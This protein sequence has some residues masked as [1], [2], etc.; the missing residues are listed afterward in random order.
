MVY[1]IITFMKYIFFNIN[2]FK[3]IES[4]WFF[5]KN[6]MVPLIGYNGSGK[7]NFL[8]SIHWFDIYNQKDGALISNKR[9]KDLKLKITAEILLKGS[10]DSSVLNKFFKDL[11]KK[12]TKNSLLYKELCGLNYLNN[13]K[14]RLILE[15]SWFEGVSYYIEGTEEFLS[16]L[17]KEKSE[18]ISEYNA[19]IKV[20]FNNLPWIYLFSGNESKELIIQKT[21]IDPMSYNKETRNKWYDILN[22]IIKRFSTDKKFDLEYIITK[23]VTKYEIEQLQID[24]RKGLN[25]DLNINDIFYFL[26]GGDSIDTELW[27]NISKFDSNQLVEIEISIVEK[28]GDNLSQVVPMSEMST[29]FKNLINSYF[30]I[31]FSGKQENRIFLL[32]EPTNY[33]SNRI[34]KLL[35]EK[36]KK[37]TDEIKSSFLFSTHNPFGI[38]LNYIKTDEII[39]AEKNSNNLTQIMNINDCDFSHEDTKNYINKILKFTDYS[40]NNLNIEKDKINVIVEGLSDFRILNCVLENDKYNILIMEGFKKYKY[41]MNSCSKNNC[42]F[43]FIIDTN[44]KEKEYFDEE[45]NK[46]K[47]TKNILKK[48]FI[49]LNDININFNQIEDLVNLEEWIA[50]NNHEHKNYSLKCKLLDNEFDKNFFS[51]IKLTT[52]NFILLKTSIEN[53]VN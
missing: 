3:N 44:S 26:N 8:E 43:I 2:N 32:D 30:L 21:V 38:D 6:N 11:G 31:S 47:I 34:M 36:M 24:I 19:Y 45:I 20:L 4:G 51:K 46:L 1:D 22:T 52:D 7:T 13:D 25:S 9:Y 28:W 27:F 42:K 49:F 33:L 39:I 15:P 18:Y 29:G 53:K 12:L 17:F 48:H 40:I 37:D 41:W 35:W 5:P 23:N 14:F 16:K 50:F 10:E